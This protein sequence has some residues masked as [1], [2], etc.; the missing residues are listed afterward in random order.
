MPFRNAVVVDVPGDVP[1]IGPYT[2]ILEQPDNAGDAT[3][4]GWE[5]GATWFP[6]LPGYWDGLGI[7][8]SLTLLESEQEIPIL[9]ET[10]DITGFDILPLGGVSETSYSTILAYDREDFNARLSWFWRDDFY[11]NNEA[12]LF[13]NPLQVWRSAEESLDF[14]FTWN[15]NDNWTAT[16]DATNITEP[17]FHWNYGDQP[18]LF[19]FHN[20]LYSRTFAVGVRYNFG[21]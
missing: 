5:F 20:Y 21:Q 14:Q 9:N 7:Q 13:A 15:I 16:F 8:A 19:N 4:D 11:N 17:T 3:L 2:Y 10:G 12:A 1:D 18:T 6:D